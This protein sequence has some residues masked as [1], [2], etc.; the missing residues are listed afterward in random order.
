MVVLVELEIEIVQVEL[1]V[2][3]EQFLVELE[4]VLHEVEQLVQA[5]QEVE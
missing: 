4:L 1:V 2:L 5:R 3:G